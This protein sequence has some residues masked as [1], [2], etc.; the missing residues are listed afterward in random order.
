V[1]SSDLKKWEFEEP[2]VKEWTKR[3]HN[4]D[5]TYLLYTGTPAGS[6]SSF[7][8][9]VFKKLKIMDR[10]TGSYQIISTEKIFGSSN[11]ISINKISS[12][13]DG[14]YL[15]GIV[16]SERI[17]DRGYTFEGTEFVKKE[18]VSM[19]IMIWR[20]SDNTLVNCYE[21]EVSNTYENKYE[22]IGDF[23][24]MWHK[25][26]PYLFMTKIHKLWR[27]DIGHS[28]ISAPVQIPVENIQGNFGIEL[29]DFFIK[30]YGR[31]WDIET[32]KKF[33]PWYE[34]LDPFDTTNQFPLYDKNPVPV[35]LRDY[36]G[37]D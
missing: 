1:C 32:G 33:W 8:S 18:L 11:L 14:R 34:A 12:S 22:N 20:V 4:D 5:S 17:T 19:K 24:F 23:I 10:N 29:S 31:I 13:P 37:G 26:K 27:F 25:T 3:E 36:W 6:N 15:A 9:F 16:T 2:N 7:N 21:Q 30:I 35:K 28:D